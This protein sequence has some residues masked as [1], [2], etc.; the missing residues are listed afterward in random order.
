MTEK[1]ER[2]FNYLFWDQMFDVLQNS[3]ARYI[4]E[5]RKQTDLNELY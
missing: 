1:E 2:E 4:A 3:R 5:E